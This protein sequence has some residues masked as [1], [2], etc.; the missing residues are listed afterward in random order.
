MWMSLEQSI[1]PK[2]Q[3]SHDQEIEY[4][5]ALPVSVLAYALRT[6]PPVTYISESRLA[7]CDSRTKFKDSSI[8]VPGGSGYWMCVM[9]A[10]WTPIAFKC[11]DPQKRPHS[12]NGQLQ[13]SSQFFVEIS[14]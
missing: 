1:H 11:L 2:I 6:V 14:T 10:H 5:K 13:T 7:G 8:Y 4:F 9:V 12:E 3:H